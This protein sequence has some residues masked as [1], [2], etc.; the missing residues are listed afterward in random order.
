MF[1][2]QETDKNRFA[3]SY[4]TL[5]LGEKENKINHCS[6]TGRDENNPLLMNFFVFI[7]KCNQNH[8]CMFF[9]HKNVV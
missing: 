2:I 7:I 8:D 4:F 1:W 9:S 6:K 3:E 5:K